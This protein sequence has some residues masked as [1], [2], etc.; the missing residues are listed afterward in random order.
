[1]KLG[2][3]KE[4]RFTCFDG[5][6]LRGDGFKVK[7]LEEEGRNGRETVARAYVASIFLSSPVFCSILQ[8]I[9]AES[10]PLAGSG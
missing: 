4:D 8:F 1:M 6:E 10:V 3:E 5:G 7:M 9:I 2:E